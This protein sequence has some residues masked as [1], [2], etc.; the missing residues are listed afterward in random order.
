MFIN[1]AQSH[2]WKRLTFWRINFVAILEKDNTMA[3]KVWFYKAAVP[4]TLYMFQNILN[5]WRDA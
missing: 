2:I 5:A 1:G 3:I 4:G